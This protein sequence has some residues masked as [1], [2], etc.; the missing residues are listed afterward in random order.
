[1]RPSV[2]M[3]MIALACGDDIE[4]RVYVVKDEIRGDEVGG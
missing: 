1:M 2:E 3:T 4:E